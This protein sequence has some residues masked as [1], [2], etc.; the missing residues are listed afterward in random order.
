MTA[1]CGGGTSSPKL[2]ASE[3]VQYTSALLAGIMGVYDMAWLIPVIPLLQLAPLELSAFC[4]TDPPA[5]PTFTS[6][7]TN[8]LLQ[9][10]FGGDFDSG[11]SKFRDLL[12]SMLWR[13]TCDCDSGSPAP[14]SPPSIPAGTPITQYVPVS[15]T[16][17]GQVAS[18]SAAS[19]THWANGGSLNSSIGGVTPT[20]GVTSAIVT[21]HTVGTTGGGWS[22][23]ITLTARDS[24]FLQVGPASTITLPPTGTTAITMPIPAGTIFIQAQWSGPG[25]ASKVDDVW[26]TID[27]FC[28]DTLGTSGTCATDPLVSSI[29]DNILRQVNLIQRQ[30]VPFAYVDGDS[31][32]VSGTGEISLQGVLGA[33]IDLTTIPARVG[34]S[35]GTPDELFD[36]GFIRWGDT[37]GWGP[38]V[39]IDTDPLIHL[40]AQA[41]IY[42]RLG[43]TLTPGVIATIT[44]LLREP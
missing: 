38:A 11:L 7:E 17:C 4:A 29:L 36:I 30:Q 10:Q 26:W 37:S 25:G 5:E 40:P 31:N 15:N 13:E 8:A 32:S 23:P 2:G 9:L 16:P 12:L 14:F 34:T 6:A 18:F 42:T 41:G 28:G 21:F 44:T 19:P 33:R 39:R 27:Y 43:Y 24:S 1:I 35:A 22:V 20:V 3:F